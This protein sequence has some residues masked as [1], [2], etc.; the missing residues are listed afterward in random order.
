MRIS[1]SH[2][3]GHP[4][5]IGVVV[6]FFFLSSSFFLLVFAFSKSISHHKTH[7]YSDARL[8]ENVDGKN[9]SY[10]D[11]QFKQFNATFRLFIYC[12]V[13]HLFIFGNLHE[14]PTRLTAHKYH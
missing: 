8:A 3:T 4:D 5:S 14:N 12:F 1:Q 7:N 2:G 11:L 10:T 13:L 6:D 9:G